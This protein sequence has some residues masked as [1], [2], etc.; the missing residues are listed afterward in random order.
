MNQK[1]ESPTMQEEQQ[2]KG[3]ARKVQEALRALGISST[4]REMPASTRTAKDAAEA[5][6][7]TVGQIAKSLVFRCTNS[8]KPILIIASGT[9]RVNERTMAGV[10][11]E[12][13]ERAT[14]EFV[15]DVTGY[16]I[17]G[18]PPVGHDQ[19]L[20]IWMDKALLAF[21][22]IWAAAGTPESVFDI[23]PDELAIITKATVIEL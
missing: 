17:G 20:P 4:V 12:P 9:N 6:G 19:Q 3:S 13:I 10:V 16:A 8:G 2:I 7:C 1:T 14:P 11:G 21:E 15:R 18:I 5:I 22:R 23:R